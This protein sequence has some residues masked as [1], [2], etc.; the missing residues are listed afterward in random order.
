MKTL[1]IIRALF[2]SFILVASQLVFANDGKY[3]QAMKSNIDAIYKA[4]TIE[5]LQSSTNAF[6]RIAI[7]EPQKWEPNYYAAF[8]YIMIGN[9]EKDP[10]KK[11]QHLDRALSFIEKAKAIVPAESEVIALEGFVHMLRITIDPPSRGQ[12]YAPMAMQTFGKAISTNPENPR[13]LSLLAQ[14]QYGSAQFFGGST[15]EACATLTKALEKFDTFKSE[16]T[17][18]PTWGKGMAEGLKSQCK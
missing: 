2:A 9:K 14:M 8:G 15:T 5:G 17:L 3:E 11:D 4:Q 7:A 16:N 12:K 18:A 1:I 10:S 13:A 6:E